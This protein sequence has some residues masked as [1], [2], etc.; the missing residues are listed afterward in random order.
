MITADELYEISKKQKST[1]VKEVLNGVKEHII[2]RC[3]EEANKGNTWYSIYLKE[4]YKYT[5]DLLFKECIKLVKEFENKRYKVSIDNA[6][7]DIKINYIL[8]F[9]W[10]GNVVAREGIRLGKNYHLYD[11]DNGIKK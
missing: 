11:T 6:G 7:N 3:T 1:L 9:S 2:E 8:T 10:D 4:T 5:E